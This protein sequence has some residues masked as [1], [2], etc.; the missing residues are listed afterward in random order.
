MINDLM[1]SGLI[2]NAM[3]G[4][5]A[6]VALGMMMMMVRK[7]GR[8]VVLPKPEEVVGLPPALENQNDIVGEADE[9]QTAMEGIELDDAEL[10]SKK[11]LESVSEMVKK[12][13]ADSAKI[14]NRWVV[15]AT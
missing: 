2:K 11:M 13:P 4:V 1:G 9:G 12:N 8:T 7:A 14:M 10:K 3:L 5:L 6:L 15:P